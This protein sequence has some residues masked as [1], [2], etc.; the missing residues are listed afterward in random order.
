MDRDKICD[1]PTY[2]VCD[3]NT[4]TRSSIYHDDLL[5]K[6]KKQIIIHSYINHNTSK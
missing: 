6:H 2:N 4:E 3:S 1:S 5:S